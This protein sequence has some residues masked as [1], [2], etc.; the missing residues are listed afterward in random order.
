MFAFFKNKINNNENNSNKTKFELSCTILVSFEYAP[1]QFRHTQRT[2]YNAKYLASKS[3]FEARNQLINDLLSEDILNSKNK[4]Y[5]FQFELKG[6]LAGDPCHEN[7]HSLTSYLDYL[8]SKNLMSE[9]V[10]DKLKKL[11]TMLE[12]EKNGSPSAI[13]EGYD[14]NNPT[15]NESKFIPTEH[16]SSLSP[17]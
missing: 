7:F 5:S 16:K 3:D 15:L 4:V 13:K 12:K 17:Q 6:Q 10:D 14:E 8:K 11:I 1:K 2:P 9:V